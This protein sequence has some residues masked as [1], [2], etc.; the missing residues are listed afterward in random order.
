MRTKNKLIAAFCM[1]LLTTA[2][3]A[4]T[5]KA[6]KTISLCDTE[7]LPINLGTQVLGIDASATGGQWQQ[8]NATDNSQ[9]IN[10]K[11]KNVLK[12]IDLT[13]G[14]YVF[15]YTAND[16]NPCAEEGDKFRATVNI[17]ETPK[18]VNINVPLC[19]GDTRDV[20]LK[21]LISATFKDKYSNIAYKK[22]DGTDI[23]NGVLA[24]SA[25][26][27]GTIE[28]TYEIIGVTNS[29]Y[30]CTLS[31]TISVNITRDADFT[32][33]DFSGKKALC[34]TKM[35]E[36]INLNAELGIG[37]TVN[38]TTAAGAP[39]VTSGVVDLSGSVA[40][41]TYVYNFTI[42]APGTSCG[43]D[44][45]TG[46]YTLTIT[47]DLT[48][49]LNATKQKAICKLNTPNAN[50][51]MFQTLGIN[52]PVQSGVWEPADQATPDTYI[53][54]GFFDASKAPAGTYKY[55][56]RVSNAADLCGI[57]GK[58]SGILTF[59]IE[60]GGNLLDG[61]VQLCSVNLP[62]DLNLS[63]YIAGISASTTTWKDAAGAVV[64]SGV[65]DAS[66]LKKGTYEYI[67]ETGSSECKSTGSLY[68]S[69][70]DKL[71]N[72]TDRS[73]KYCLTDTGSDAISLDGLL[74]VAGITGSWSGAGTG[75]TNYN[76]TTHM[77]NGR[78][79]GTGTYTFT[80]TADNASGCGL[81]NQ[82]ATITVIITDN[83]TN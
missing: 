5:Y 49:E 1:L 75:N 43:L 17:L 76:T 56:L 47:D 45:K 3:F 77:F 55:Q 41:G 62:S 39:A 19:E 32:N 65:L 11:A 74:A 50:I 9:I 21:T 51:D 4:Q 29:E 37:A 54:N 10:P 22:A 66:R 27:E 8:V 72:F 83:L 59:I 48:D 33:K 15:V 13:P 30:P 67:Y 6:D 70:V 31:S 2:A 24:I 78:A 20:D 81:A 58:T 60:N 46:A 61:T 52:I 53:K 40:T 35:P 26:D 28:A 80:F 25:N 14:T 12:A 18:P 34:V 73:V 36:K 57:A 7:A 44:G 69:V 64:S 42:S 38:W 82:T 68:I 23:V 79:A 71:S 63:K 16:S